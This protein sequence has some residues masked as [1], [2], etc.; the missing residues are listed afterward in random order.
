MVTWLDERGESWHW[1]CVKEDTV[2][3]SVD[4]KQERHGGR[5]RKKG[6]GGRSGRG[7]G[8]G[9]ETLDKIQSSWPGVVAHAFALSTQEAE[10]GRLCEFKANLG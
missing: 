5:R 10:A 7:G 8:G 1:E 6:G 3:L 9:G 2:Y 4:G